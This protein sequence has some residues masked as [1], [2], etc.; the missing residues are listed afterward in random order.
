VS[1]ARRAAILW[2]FALLTTVLFAADPAALQWKQLHPA[3]ALPP[4]AAFASAYDPLS[5]K[6]IVFGGIDA[7]GAVSNETWTYDGR[8]WERVN[9]KV[10]PAARFGTSM[11]YD[12]QIQKIVMFGGTAGFARFNDTW[13]WDGVTLNWKHARTRHTP[14]ATSNAMLFSDPVNGRV[15]MFGG[16]RSQFYSRDTYQWNGT[17]W[18]LLNPTNSPFPRAGGISVVDPVRKNVVVFGGISDNWITQNTWTWDGQ[19][20]TQQSPTTQPDTLYFTH[21][22]YDPLLKRVIVFGGGSQAVDQSATWSWNGADWVTLAPTSSPTAREQF[23]TVWDGTTHQFLIFGGL[24]FTS[25]EVLGDTWKL[26]GK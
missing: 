26:V 11:A 10:T 17:D 4:R 21:G 20:W 22:G 12:S 13:L 2:L 25:G 14:P 5:K 15:D 9:T 6:V 23:G 1:S 3:T 18:N 16:R 7:A 19:D 24:D 8:T